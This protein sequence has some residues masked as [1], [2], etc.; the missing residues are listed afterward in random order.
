MTS[1]IEREKPRMLT[2]EEMELLRWD[3]CVTMFLLRTMREW[4]RL[5]KLGGQH[6]S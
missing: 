3:L 1:P 6:E 5:R 4:E 2:Q